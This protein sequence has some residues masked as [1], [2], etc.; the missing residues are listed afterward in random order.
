[1]SMKNFAALA[2]MAI[3][4]DGLGSGSSSMYGIPRNNANDFDGSLPEPPLPKGCDWYYFDDTGIHVNKN[5][6]L[7]AYKCIASSEKSAIKKFNKWVAK[8]K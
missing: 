7:Y 2:S 8:Q 5:N 4:F 1:M 3:M 6:G